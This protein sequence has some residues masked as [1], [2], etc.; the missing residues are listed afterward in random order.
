MHV[1][2]FFWRQK[3][4]FLENDKELKMARVKTDFFTKFQDDGKMIDI[5]MPL[6]IM[7]LS[8]VKLRI[9]TLGIM[10]VRIMELSITKIFIT[11]LSI[12]ILTTTTLINK[13]NDVS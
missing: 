5:I 1:W 3:S 11:I 8:V 10:T 13:Q 6:G 7:T 9:M 4:Q 12:M 2:L